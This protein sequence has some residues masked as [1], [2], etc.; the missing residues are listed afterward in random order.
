MLFRAVI[1]FVPVFHSQ[2]ASGKGAAGGKKD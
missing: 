2:A 1:L